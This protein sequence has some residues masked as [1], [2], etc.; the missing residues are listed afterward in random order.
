MGA[1]ARCFADSRP[2]YTQNINTLKPIMR[3][4]SPWGGHGRP[5]NHKK[6]LRPAPLRAST[7]MRFNRTRAGVVGRDDRCRKRWWPSAEDGSRRQLAGGGQLRY[8]LLTS[9][10]NAFEGSPLECTQMI[11]RCLDGVAVEPPPDPRC[12]RNTR[13]NAQDI[14]NV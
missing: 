3:K 4:V 5:Q 13:K 8:K 11:Y 7:T 1:C 6:G 10:R 2:A 14:N 9:A 12:C